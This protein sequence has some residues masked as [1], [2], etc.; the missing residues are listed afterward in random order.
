[1][2]TLS[3]GGRYCFCRTI[4]GPI[5]ISLSAFVPLHPALPRLSGTHPPLGFSRI[6]MMPTPSM[7]E[8][9]GRV[10]RCADSQSLS[11]PSG[12]LYVVLSAVHR[13][14]R[15][16]GLLASPTPGLFEE[17]LYSTSRAHLASSSL[18]V[19]AWR[20]ESAFLQGLGSSRAGRSA[21]E[22]KTQSSRPLHLKP[23]F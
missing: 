11:T 21:H 17:G 14:P 9:F 3:I 4:S 5:I 8:S 22:P 2:T 10:C 1:M 19:H 13:K 15:S 6:A 7:S 23:T 20:A 12:S 18:Y 16:S